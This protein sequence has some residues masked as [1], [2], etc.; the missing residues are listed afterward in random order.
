MET[1]LFELICTVAETSSAKITLKNLKDRHPEFADRL[2]AIKGLVPAPHLQEIE[3]SEDDE[4]RSYVVQYDPH[5]MYYF[6]A[7]AGKTAVKNDDL[8]V[9]GVNFD[10]LFRTVTDALGI[11]SGI[12]PQIISDHNIWFLGSAWLNKRKTPVILCRRIFDE[13]VAEVM[14]TYLRDKHSNEPALLIAISSHIP[15]YFRL[16]GHNRLVLM[17]DVIDK[18]AKNLNFNMQYLAEKMGAGIHQVG[19]SEGYRTAYIN[20]LHYQFSKL[21]AEILEVLDQA[22]RS[23]HKTEIMAQTG[24]TQEN[25]YQIF[26]TGGQYHP[27][28]N[29]IIKN[30]KKGNY[31]LEY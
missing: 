5:G 1:N 15:A 19:F 22:G 10:L 8:L 2:L 27:A 20:G 4:D 16:P 3:V 23:L 21:Q 30:D 28:W 13:N 7:I 18:Q 26:R 6:S 25:I 12:K 11:S 24:T 31:R 29:V 9:Y 14:Q 17:C